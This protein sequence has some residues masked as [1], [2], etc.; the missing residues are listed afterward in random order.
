MTAIG[1]VATDETTD[2]RLKLD[3]G[4]IHKIMEDFF[5]KRLTEDPNH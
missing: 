5:A 2:G 3:Y 4:L 1:R